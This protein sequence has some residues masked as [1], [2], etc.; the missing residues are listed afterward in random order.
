[1]DIDIPEVVAELTA[2]FEEYERALLSNKPEVLIR[3]FWPDTRTIRY[4]VAENLYGADAIAAF[5]HKRAERGGA[6]QRKTTRRQI[7]TYGRDFGTTNIEYVRTEMESQAGR[8]KPGCA[9]RKAGAS[10][11]R[12]FPCLPSRIPR[13]PAWASRWVSAS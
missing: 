7:T 6:P 4:G 8:A 10:S 13:D 1:M 11:R 2:A 12:T 9:R 3:L 5:R